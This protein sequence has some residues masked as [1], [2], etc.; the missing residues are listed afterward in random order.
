MKQFIYSFFLILLLS[1]V[2][3][4]HAMEKEQPNYPSSFFTKPFNFISK[5]ITEYQEA[6]SAKEK[7]TQELFEAVRNNDINKAETA[8]KNKAN[9]NATQPYSNEHK[10]LVTPL[11]LAIAH[12]KFPI[13]K[14][15]L[16]SGAELFTEQ[17][18][19]MGFPLCIVEPLHATEKTKADL[20]E[21]IK[22][23]AQHIIN[24][25]LFYKYKQFIIHTK[26]LCPKY[27]KP[28]P[29]TP[30]PNWQNYVKGHVTTIRSL[31]YQFIE[32][33][34]ENL[35]PRVTEIFN[36]SS[37]LFGPLDTD[38]EL[39]LDN[40]LP[41]SGSIKIPYTMIKL[42]KL[43]KSEPN[44]PTIL[45]YKHLYDPKKDYELMKKLAQANTNNQL[46]IK[47]DE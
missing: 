34:K 23:Y 28:E 22:I 21:L 15:L 8:L 13:V 46:L 2:F 29:N 19:D 44:H 41:L 38:E 1:F 43:S 4:G 5:K 42:I 32:L 40:G 36:T 47:L 10:H 27:N 16:D 6:N 17:D 45:L 18:Y 11:F 7:A 26:N 39:I 12:I 33:G 31:N 25:N 14:L 9:T 35:I 30:T 24:K 20:L 37:D 3:I